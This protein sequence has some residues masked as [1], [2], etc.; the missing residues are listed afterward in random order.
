[1]PITWTFD[2]D[3]DAAVVTF[4]DPYGFDEWCA[5]MDEILAAHPAPRF[6]ADARDTKAPSTQLI[7]NVLHY[8]ARRANDLAGSVVAIVTSDPGAY[9]MA[10]M[11]EIRS[12]V[13]TLGITIR[14]FMAYAEAVAWIRP[15][16]PGR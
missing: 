10:R 1:M 15:S 16:E 9:G 4:T 11:L 12:E 13:T 8:F 14:A 3:V 2:T 7:D 6:I 5:L